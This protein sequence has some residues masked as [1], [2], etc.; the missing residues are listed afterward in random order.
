[1]FK[2]NQSPEHFCTYSGHSK[3]VKDVQF[4]TDGT[5]FLSA[6]YDRYVKL[7]DVETGK[8]M[9]KFT[10]DKFPLCLKYYPEDDNY[11]LVGQSDKKIICYDVRDQSVQQLYDYHNDEVR[12]ITFFDRNRRFV[13][14]GL[15]NHLRVF[16]WSIPVETKQI[17]DPSI[18]PIICAIA[19]RDQTALITQC[20]DSVM[21][22]FDM[23][24]GFRFNRK[25]R[26]QGHAIT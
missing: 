23:E 13:S 12:T 26:F 25:K 5:Q 21:R 8:V 9:S 22:C 6:S 17:K 11:F 4:N 18:S 3:S 10:K 20:M 15:D 24:Q 14:T 7:W 2:I 1:I 19:K 16:E